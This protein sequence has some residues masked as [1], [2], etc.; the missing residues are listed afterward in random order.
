MYRTAV[1]LAG[2]RGK[3]LGSYTKTIPK[4]LLPIQGRPLLDIILCSLSQFGFSRIILAVNHLA[5]LIRSFCQDGSKWNV[6]IEYIQETEPLGTIGPVQQICNLP[7]NFLILN[8]DILT[9]LD[10]GAFFDQHVREQNLFTISYVEQKKKLSYGI[11][12][13]E[14]QFLSQ[15]KEKPT[16]IYPVN[17]GVYMANKKIVDFI[18]KKTFFGLDQLL[19]RL[20]VLKQPIATCLH[21]GK[22]LDIGSIKNYKKSSRFI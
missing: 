21:Q 19:S 13:I 11:L 15:F 22:W 17:M 18:P 9:D 20:L 8:S 6:S 4:S 14:N 1:I 16:V 3:R 7:E 12:E 2:G 10:Y 5:D